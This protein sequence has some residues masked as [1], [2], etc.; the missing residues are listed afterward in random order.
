VGGSVCLSVC[1]CV[2]VCVCVYTSSLLSL[3]DFCE[4][5]KRRAVPGAARADSVSS[6][7]ARCWLLRCVDENVVRTLARR[8]PRWYVCV[9]VRVGVE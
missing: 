3:T 8:P 7:R 1:V 9:C 5:K 6:Y 4:K 2:C